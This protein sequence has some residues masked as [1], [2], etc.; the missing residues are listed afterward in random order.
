MSGIF[1]STSDT[2]V[3]RY[4]GRFVL[5]LQL[6]A[7]LK[8]LFTIFSLSAKMCNLAVCL[9]YICFL[10]LPLQLGEDIKKPVAMF[11]WGWRGGGYVFQNMIYISTIFFNINFICLVRGEVL[12]H[13]QCNF[14]FFLLLLPLPGKKTHFETK[15]VK[16]EGEASIMDLVKYHKYWSHA[17]VFFGKIFQGFKLFFHGSGPKESIVTGLTNIWR[18][19]NEQ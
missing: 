13:L 18:N 15:T 5:V 2:Q 19:K 12:K 16:G 4:F 10:F 11:V 1:Q 6:K 17:T 14:L 3:Y 9:E 8:R 7:V